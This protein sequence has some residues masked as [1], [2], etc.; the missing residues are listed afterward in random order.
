MYIQ[1]QEKDIFLSLYPNSFTEVPSSIFSDPEFFFIPYTKKFLQE[2]VS[3]GSVSLRD[4]TND[5]LHFIFQWF[6]ENKTDGCVTEPRKVQKYFNV[7][8]SL[9]HTLFY[10][11]VVS[12]EWR[13]QEVVF[14]TFHIHMNIFIKLKVSKKKTPKPSDVVSFTF[15]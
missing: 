2:T 3:S 11:R 8:L 14:G 13:K 15:M 7:F 12:M 6:V 10:E 5:C 4:M 1:A 9:T